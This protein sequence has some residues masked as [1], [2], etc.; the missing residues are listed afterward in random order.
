[1]FPATLPVTVPAI[2]GK[3]IILFYHQNG[4]KFILDDVTFDFVFDNSGRFG[5]TGL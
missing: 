3:K 5:N 4:K 2:S 1:M